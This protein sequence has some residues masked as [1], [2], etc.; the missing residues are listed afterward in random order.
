MDLLE[1]YFRGINWVHEENQ[2]A[3]PSSIDLQTTEIR[4]ELNSEVSTNSSY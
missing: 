1:I 2:L 3:N 4:L